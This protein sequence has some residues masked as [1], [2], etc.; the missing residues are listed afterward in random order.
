V[1][2]F[3]ANF[4]GI[5]QFDDCLG[6]CRY[7]A[8]DPKLVVQCVNAVTGWNMSFEDAFNVGLRVVNQLR[9]FN[10]AHGMKAEN[11]RPSKRYGSIPVDGPCKGKN[12][13][14]KWDSMLENYYRLM[15][16]DTKTGIPLPET[17]KKL[18]LENLI[19]D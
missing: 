9:M 3:N 1:S 19:K 17:L 13:T 11:E 8:P 5:R 2:T 15:G 12:I 10:F 7:A 6:T 16:W 4:N 18:S 14:E